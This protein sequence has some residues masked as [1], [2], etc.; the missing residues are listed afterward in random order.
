MDEVPFIFIP[1]VT[2]QD[3]KILGSASCKCVCT[4]RICMWD[5]GGWERFSVRFSTGSQTS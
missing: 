3:R 5:W 1:H 4:V 2:R